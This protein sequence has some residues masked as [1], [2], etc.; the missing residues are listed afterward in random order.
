M[1]KR[2]LICFW[3]PGITEET[4][5]PALLATPGGMKQLHPPLYKEPEKHPEQGE[6]TEIPFLRD[7][8]ETSM[9]SA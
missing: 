4:P 1:A 7:L 8:I 9:K 2:K 5:Y 3:G 6:K